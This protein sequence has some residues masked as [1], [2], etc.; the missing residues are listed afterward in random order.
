MCTAGIVLRL[1]TLW[2]S[3]GCYWVPNAHGMDPPIQ[4]TEGLLNMDLQLQYLALLNIA[5]LGLLIY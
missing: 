2:S 5:I 4:P 1:G 3:L